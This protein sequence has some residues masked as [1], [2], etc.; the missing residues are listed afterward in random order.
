[1]CLEYDQASRVQ[2]I[3]LSEK[4]FEIRADVKDGV[5]VNSFFERAIT[6]AQNF[7]KHQGIEDVIIHRSLK[8]PELGA[9]GKFH[10]VFPLKRE[11]ND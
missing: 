7:F 5:N 2:L 8:P 3:Q 1:M 4:E 10:E 6:D 11:K 9:S